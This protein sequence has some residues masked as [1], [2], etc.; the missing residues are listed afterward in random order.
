M[1]L[2]IDVVVI[3]S[4]ALTVIES[5][6]VAVRDPLSVTRTV[7]FAVP[8]VVGVPASAPDEASNENPA[9]NV[10]TATAQVYGVVPPAAAKVAE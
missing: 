4:A 2:C 5:T 8:A 1:P 3:E 7:K 6:W 9:G 10:P